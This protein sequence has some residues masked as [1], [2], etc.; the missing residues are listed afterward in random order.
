VAKSS[1]AFS[2]IARAYC[3]MGDLGNAKAALYSVA[4]AERAQVRRECQSVGTDLP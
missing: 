3:R 2:I 1:R 4:A